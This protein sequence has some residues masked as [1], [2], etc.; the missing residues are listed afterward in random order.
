MRW[1]DQGTGERVQHTTGR[2]T[3]MVEAQYFFERAALALG[4]EVEA[5]YDSVVNDAL[6]AAGLL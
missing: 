4:G 3:G 6:R 1:Q 5:I 2:H